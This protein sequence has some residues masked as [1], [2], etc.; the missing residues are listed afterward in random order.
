MVFSV[1]AHE[2][3]L[4]IFDITYMQ[5]MTPQI[6]QA[7]TTPTQYTT[8][9]TNVHTTDNSKI[10]VTTLIDRRD[11]K[12]YSIS[13]FNDGQCWMT[14]NL[15]L[16]LSKDHPLSSISSDLNTIAKWTPENGT[17]YMTGTWPSDVATAKDR[18]YYDSSN[19]AN[20]V[21]YNWTAATAGHTTEALN[22]TVEDSI[23][24]KNWRLPVRQGTRSYNEL[25]A[26]YFFV[27][28]DDLFSGAMGLTASGY[29][30]FGSGRVDG[31][32]GWTDT[33]GASYPNGGQSW[34][35]EA[36]SSEDSAGE[37]YVFYVGKGNDKYPGRDSA[38]STIK[39]HGLSVRCVA[40]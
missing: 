6:C 33:A 21:Y 25:M 31:T 15:A 22:T 7:T 3:T 13:K 32:P 19:S 30:P 8:A 5:E 27:Y 34:L 28:E 4:T 24:P 14:Q 37:A 17:Q 20:G 40:R 16:E 2:Q 18:S 36:T 23:C 38:R 26:P 1:I 29:Y 39:A 11:G 35:W 10:P 12:T 9:I